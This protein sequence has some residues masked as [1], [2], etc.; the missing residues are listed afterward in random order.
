METPQLLPLS[1]N[2]QARAHVW[3]QLL[4]AEAP[5][6]FLQGRTTDV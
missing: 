1:L 6:L 5:P 2:L 4:S 3:E